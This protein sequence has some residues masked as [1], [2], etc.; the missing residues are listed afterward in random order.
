MDMNTAP[1][2]SISDVVEPSLRY[3]VFPLRLRYFS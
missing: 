2:V 1:C 3:A